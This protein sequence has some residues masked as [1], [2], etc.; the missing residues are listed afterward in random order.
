MKK[1][2]WSSI[3]LWALLF[4][5]G[6][7]A[8]P[9]NMPEPVEE[10]VISEKMQLNPV[11]EPAEKQAS[12]DLAE[13]TEQKNYGYIPYTGPLEDPV[14]SHGEEVRAASYPSKLDPRTDGKVTSVKNQYKTGSCWAHATMAASE[15]SLLK[16]GMAADSIDLSEFQL[17]Y[18][19]YAK[20]FDALGNISDD[21]MSITPDTV[22]SK[23][24]FGGNAVVAM[25][26][27]A[28]WGGPVAESAAP[29]IT[30]T[31]HTDTTTTLAASLRNTSLYHLKE[32]KVVEFKQENK[33]AIKELIMQYG[34]VTA[35]YYCDQ[36]W[37]K[38]VGN[39]VTYYCP[40]TSSTNHAIEIVGWDDTYPVANFM[41]AASGK[42]ASCPGAWLCKNSWGTGGTRGDGYFWMSYDMPDL[43]ADCVALSY[44]DTAKYQNIYQYDG[45]NYTGS[46]SEENGYVMNVYTA[47]G[48]S[49]GMEQ[50]DAVGIGTGANGTYHIQVY[51]NPVWEKDPYWDDYKDITAYDYKSDIT[52]FSSVYQGY[53]SVPLKEPV[54]I[55]DGDTFAVVVN[56]DDEKSFACTRSKAYQTTSDNITVSAADTRSEGQSYY[57]GDGKRWKDYYET[58]TFRIKAF[59]N[60]VKKT[61]TNVTVTMPLSECKLI[62]YDSDEMENESKQLTATMTP[63]DAVGGLHYKSSDIKVATVSDTGLVTAVG[64]GE[65][66]ITA[67]CLNGSSASCK[68]TVEQHYQINIE[69]TLDG[70]QWDGGTEHSFTLR[71][72]QGNRYPNHAYVASGSYTVYDGDQKTDMVFEITTYSRTRRLAYLTN[73]FY[74]EDGTLLHRQSVEQYTKL[75][76]TGPAPEKESDAAYDY[77]FT[78]WTPSLSWNCQ[79]YTAVFKKTLKPQSVTIKL[80][81]DFA[82]WEGE[83]APEI[84]FCSTADPSLIYQNGDAVPAGKYQIL[85]DGKKTDQMF[86]TQEKEKF[87]LYLDFYTV[88]FLAGEDGTVLQERAYLAG[89]LPS[90]DGDIPVKEADGTYQYTFTGWSADL[91]PVEKKITYTAKYQAELLPQPVNI[92]CSLSNNDIPT[93]AKVEVSF[94]SKEDE[95]TVYPNGSLVPVGEYHVCINGNEIGQSITVTPGQA[96]DGMLQFYL[97]RFIDALSGQVL[98]ESYYLENET[99]VIADD[100][101]I[102]YEDDGKFRYKIIGWDSP[103]EPAHEARDYVFQVE[104][105]AISRE[106]NVTCMLN[107]TTWLSSDDPEE[108]KASYPVIMVENMQTKEQYHTDCSVPAGDYEILSDE[109]QTGITVKVTQDSTI[110]KVTLSYYTVTFVDETGNVLQREV[111]L[112][113]EM[114]SYK[115]EPLEKEN[116]QQYCY[117]YTGFSPALESVQGMVT[118]R[119]TWE[120][121]DTQAGVKNAANVVRYFPSFEEAQIYADQSED[122]TLM[123]IR[124]VDHINLPAGRTYKV[125]LNGCSVLKDIQMDS[126]QD[127]TKSSSLYLLDSSSW[128]MGAVLGNVYMGTGVTPYGNTYLYNQANIYGA[129]VAQTIDNSGYINTVAAFTSQVTNRKAIDTVACV[130]ANAVLKNLEGAYIGSIKQ[131]AGIFQNVGSVTRLENNSGTVDNKGLIEIGD[132]A[133]VGNDRKPETE[134]NKKDEEEK[135]DEEDEED[136]D[137]E[138]EEIY[139]IGECFIL[140]SAEYQITTKDTVIYKK[141]INRNEKTVQIPTTVRNGGNVFTVTGIGANAFKNNKRL[142]SVTISSRVTC[143]GKNA[144]YNCKK[145]KKVTIKSKVINTVG[146]SAFKNIAKNAK[147]KVPGKCYKQYKRIFKGRVKAGMLKKA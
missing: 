142:K 130:P 104:A 12:A 118:Y 117:T 41:K 108:K 57:S 32:G 86:T 126:P 85:I 54:Y 137:E 30:A 103:F 114:P 144:F 13:E 4:S 100:Q 119:A 10:R 120:M 48:N 95:K 94:K 51:V 146:K 24:N 28:S 64:P 60:P 29:S 39:T 20:P 73:Y 105:A 69:L 9:V 75:V 98:K 101:I 53:Y 123:L 6:V 107:D 14:L 23:L 131:N 122:M 18:F 49:G 141:H 81:K 124:D 68:V 76:Y 99:P 40:N 26:Q 38:V 127:A 50:L 106:I 112:Q 121:G 83:A 8:Q 44:E 27:L 145:L 62:C 84:A 43:G 128:N 140:G 15:S 92:R 2:I 132:P 97:I 21:L 1:R 129:A 11:Y 89:T 116:T 5:V 16:S 80:R 63:A 42:T 87:E 133:W 70:E 102:N 67:F 47:K 19:Y 82:L 78:G 74:N 113:G 65:C 45:C 37:E 147:I 66:E 34:G 58:C 25:W 36:S 110:N 46:I 90:Y 3:I 33:E 135:A 125:D 143:I 55:K 61:E 31:S 56:W 7:S 79:K 72:A 22:A 136:E 139:V 134:Q 35:S 17:A 138:E 91:T 111:Y 71:D 77:I 88:T 115:G 93:T 59:T 109:K 52:D 96:Y